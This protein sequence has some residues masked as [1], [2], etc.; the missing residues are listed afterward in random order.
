MEYDFTLSFKLAASEADTDALIERLGAAGCDDALAGIG[1]PGRIALN[2]TREASTAEEAIVSALRDVRRAI[3]TAILVE[4]SPDLVGL[5]DV[6]EFVGMTRQNMRKLS[7]AHCDSFPVPVHSGS[8][9]LWHL[10]HV[11]RWLSDRGGYEIELPIMEVADVTMQI[12][13]I[14]EAALIERRVRREVRELVA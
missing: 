1:Q 3:P 5:T 11:L 7:L 2:F 13:L 6:A 8:V 9:A 10:A 14:K 12:N 4:A